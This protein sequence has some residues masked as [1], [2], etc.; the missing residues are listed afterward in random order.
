MSHI[1]AIYMLTHLFDICIAEFQTMQLMSQIGNIYVSYNAIYMLTYLRNICNIAEFRTMQ[2]IY[3]I[4]IHIAYMFFISAIHMS[5]NCNIYFDILFTHIKNY[6][7]S[8]YFRLRNIYF[9]YYYNVAHM[10]LMFKI[11]AHSVF[12]QSNYFIKDY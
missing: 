7:S 5:I 1:Y 12:F 8:Q 9:A 11:Y 4:S 10:T 6:A 2:H 3:H